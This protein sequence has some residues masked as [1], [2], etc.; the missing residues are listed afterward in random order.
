MNK[1]KHI[2]QA[3]ELV[4]LPLSEFQEIYKRLTDYQETL[5]NLRVP[6]QLDMAWE[7]RYL[8]PVRDLRKRLGRHF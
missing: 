7:Q 8:H 3:D 5:E 2:V 6:L 4:T 1:G